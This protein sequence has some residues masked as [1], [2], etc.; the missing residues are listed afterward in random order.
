M[1][2]GEW[3]DFYFVLNVAGALLL[4]VVTLAILV[5]GVFSLLVGLIARGW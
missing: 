4:A 1:W 2:Q 3:S 5:V